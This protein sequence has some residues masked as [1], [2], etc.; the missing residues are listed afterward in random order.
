[1]KDII[2]FLG[3]AGLYRRFIKDF[4]KLARPLARLLYKD[5]EFTFD[6]ESLVAFKLIKEALIS[7]LIV[8]AP[9]WD[10][11]FE[12]MCEALDYVEGAVLGQRIDK[13]LHVIYYMSSTTLAEQF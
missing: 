2:S 9:K 3:L 6:E 10:H 1:M 4:S 5:V 11:P 8:Q 13:K 12:I 7:T